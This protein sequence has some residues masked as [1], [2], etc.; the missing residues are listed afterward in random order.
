MSTTPTA[1]V[2]RPTPRN[3]ALLA[4]ILA[5]GGLV[6]AP[7]ETVYGLAA[8][9]LNAKACRAIF[10]AK[11]RP[12]N[13][14]LIVH[15]ASIEQAD[16]IAVLNDAAR[17]VAKLFW[18]GP[19]TLV[20]PKRDGVPDIVTSG[21]AS[22]AV[23]LPSHQLFREL[24]RRSG[25]PLA[26]PSANPF[27]Y[28][29][30]T[31]AA[32]VRDGLGKRIGHILDGGSAKIGVESTIL[33]LRDPKH[34]VLLRPGA[35]SREALARVLGRTVTVHRR[36]TPASTAAIAPGLLERHYSPRTPLTLVRKLTPALIQKTG[37]KHALLFM[38]KPAQISDRTF[39]LAEAPNAFDQAAHNLFDRLRSLDNGDWDHIHAE[40]APGSDALAL[41]VNDRLRRA[42]AKR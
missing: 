31:T 26:A 27:G 23:R 7:T 2:Y 5:E 16:E 30:P 12:A 20:L 19:L 13:D 22:V 25:C 37:D 21:L 8:D 9:A 33:D 28:V 11:G 6:A 35:V 41:A 14:P 4:R 40:L 10:R 39:W 34:P 3:L 36:A 32:H 1:R 15:V 29:S 17:K 24:I 18:P 42:A 38:Q